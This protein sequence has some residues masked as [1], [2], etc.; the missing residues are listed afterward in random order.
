MVPED[1]MEAWELAELL[2]RWAA[3]ERP[4]LEFIRAPSMSVGLYVLGA[5]ATDRQQPH[6]EDE[7]YYVVSGSGQITVGNETRPVGAG[8]TIFVAA[9]VPHRFHDIAEE[10]VIVVFFAPPEGSKAPASS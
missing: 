10:L 3:G 7:A 8:S 9:A 1:A 5:G 6:T 2:G 4:Y